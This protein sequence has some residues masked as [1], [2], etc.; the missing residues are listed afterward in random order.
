M[1]PIHNCTGKFKETVMKVK[2]FKIS[3]SNCSINKFNKINIY[4]KLMES[5]SEGVQ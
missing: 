2:D 5:L 3:Q 4:N 1:F